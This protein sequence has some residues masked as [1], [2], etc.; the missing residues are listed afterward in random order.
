M[1]NIDSRCLHPKIAI[2]A[3]G[4]RVTGYTYLKFPRSPHEASSGKQ[5]CY[6]ILA[7]PRTSQVFGALRYYSQVL[8]GTSRLLILL[9]RYRGRTSLG[10]WFLRFPSDIDVV[11][12]ACEM[13]AASIK[14]RQ[15]EYFTRVLARL[16]VA[17]TTSRMEQI[18]MA[19]DL[20]RHGVRD[21]ADIFGREYIKFVYIRVP[22]G[23]DKDK[24]AVNVI[25]DDI[26]CFGDASY[27][28]RSAIG[29]LENKHA[30]HRIMG[31]IRDQTVSLTRIAAVS[32]HK[33]A[34]V[35][36]QKLL[37][38]TSDT[39][40]DTP[41]IP[42]VS[43]EAVV[44]F[45]GVQKKMADA[46]LHRIDWLKEVRSVNP[47][48]VD[49]ST[50]GYSMWRSAWDALSDETKEQYV[51]QS[52]MTGTIALEN[53]PPASKTSKKHAPRVATAHDSGILFAPMIRTVGWS[54]GRAVSRTVSRTEGRTDG[55]S[56]GL[57]LG[58]ASG[59][60]TAYGRTDGQSDGRTVGRSASLEQRRNP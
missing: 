16:T 58:R 4:F 14:W 21:P 60:R 41:E 13:A 42:N 23:V 40:S 56:D 9:W 43:N 27:H 36:H 10:D 31:S 50:E 28:F 11:S 22:G 44:P 59:G 32:M 37:S 38:G 25:V 54:D 53:K 3:D 51:E 20:V 33:G 52:V 34:V 47:R 7:N 6:H 17:A 26:P 2:V 39:V 55:Q 19:W 46:M 57:A 35:R 48:F 24:S 49:P 5:S 1:R 8:M 29:S 30:Q 15:W 18:D 45:S 12:G